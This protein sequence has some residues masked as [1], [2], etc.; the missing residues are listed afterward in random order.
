MPWE[1]RSGECRDVVWRYSQNPVIPRNLIPFANSIF[2]SAVIP[3]KDAFAGVFRCDDRARNMQIHSGKSPDG[4]SWTIQPKRIEF[5]PDND[6][7]K[8]LGRL[9]VWLRSSR[10]LD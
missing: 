9:C 8:E 3:Y 6:R 10:M 1:D 7:V 5:V 4:L 2:N